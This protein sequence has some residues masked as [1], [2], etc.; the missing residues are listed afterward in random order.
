MPHLSPF[1]W[2]K[3][4]AASL[5]A[6]VL[7]LLAWNAMPFRTPVGRKKVESKRA[8]DRFLLRDEEEAGGH[9]TLA[10][11]PGTMTPRATFTAPFELDVVRVSNPPAP[12]PLKSQDAAPLSGG[13]GAKLPGEPGK[14]PSLDAVPLSAEEASGTQRVG[15]AAPGSAA[16]G[17]APSQFF[18]VGEQAKRILYLIDRSMS[19]GEHGAREAAFLELLK[20]LHHLP[21]NARFKVLVYN[22]QCAFVPG[23]Q[24]GWLE[25]T[26]SQIDEIAQQVV[27]LRAEG[28]TDHGPALKHA[29]AQQPDILFFLTDA[30]DLDAEHLRLAELWNRG[31]AVVHTIELTTRHHER[32]DMPLQRLA[33]ATGGVYRAVDL[34]AYWKAAR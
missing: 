33:R 31:K 25:P 7:L 11:R 4:L 30:D 5:A 13:T 18:P 20:S 6:H 2:R 8:G 27:A 14:L 16:T 19:M 28:R 12:L 26:R 3:A 29:L 23:G 15:A 22:T 32:P 21:P 24:D 9:L 1:R 34:S 10:P 17:V